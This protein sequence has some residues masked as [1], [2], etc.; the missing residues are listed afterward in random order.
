[1]TNLELIFHVLWMSS[2]ASVRAVM[3]D[4]SGLAPIWV[5]DSRWNFSVILLISAAITASR[6]FLMVL[7]KAIGLYSAATVYD[8]FPGFLIAMVYPS[9]NAIGWYPFWA[10]AFFDY[11]VYYSIWSWCFV[12]V[13]FF[14]SSLDHFGCYLLWDGNCFCTQMSRN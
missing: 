7:S 1:M 9:L 12:W 13:E 6:T 4:F 14:D 11:S 5:S 3:V 2:V 10:Q 8:F